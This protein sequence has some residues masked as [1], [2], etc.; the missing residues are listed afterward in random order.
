[1]TKKVRPPPV[2]LVL[3][4]S[5]VANPLPLAR[6]MES[7]RVADHRPQP[8]GI[9]V[10]RRLRP[11]VFVVDVTA[12]DGDAF[13]LCRRLQTDIETRHIPLIAITGAAAIGQ[14]MVTLKVNACSPESL[15]AEVQRVLDSKAAAG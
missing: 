2:V 5:A 3:G 4:T 1:M 14:F 8:D 6:L 10:A 15:H 13:A 9:A 11:D 12:A 7:C